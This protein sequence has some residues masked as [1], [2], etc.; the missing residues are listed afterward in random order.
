MFG[1]RASA[2]V[3]TAACHAA[4]IA[5]FIIQ[6]PS[7]VAASTAEPV[8][9][10]ISGRANQFFFVRDDTDDPGALVEDTNATGM[11]TYSRLT[12][13]GRIPLGDDLA[14]RGSA[15]FIANTR[16]PDN[17]DEVF[18]E[19]FGDFGRLQLGDRR[20][21]NAGM[22]ESV[23]PQAFLHMDDEIVSSAV[24]PRVEVQMRDGLTFKRFTRNATGVVYQS[25]RWNT[26][27]VAVGYYPN[28]D[29]PIS[30]AQR[31]RTKNGSESTVRS[32]GAFAD[33]IRYRALVS[34][35]QADA[36]QVPEKVSAWNALA[37]VFVG[38]F[39]IS[40][41]Y[42][43]VAP[44][45][46]LRE[47]NWAGGV[48]YVTGPWLFSG[49]FRQAVRKR[50]TTGAT[51]DKVER[52][53]FQTAYKLAPGINLGGALFQTFQRDPARLIWRSRGAILGITV[54]F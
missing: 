41:T 34:Y 13:D 33:G 32:V 40:G 30:T 16:Q 20:A 35:Y 48:M 28:G 8:T 54:G 38:P 22:V 15:R 29:T 47:R 17:T 2:V 43:N 7:A 26:L 19:L 5:F 53:T 52:L 21:A 4:G 31:M 44:I 6:S 10:T 9:V 45:F 39:E 12:I 1:R 18:I 46:G 23:A 27:D 37:D 36:V 14:V 49:D 42:M 24:R 3:R 11:F 51:F 25:P 50:E